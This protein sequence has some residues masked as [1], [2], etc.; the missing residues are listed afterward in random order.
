[1]VGIFS[2]FPGSP[3]PLQAT[4]VDISA[5][6]SRL[7][8]SVDS[9]PL[10]N[11]ST[12]C[13]NASFSKKYF[14][15]PSLRSLFSSVFQTQ[16]VSRAR[17]RWTCVPSWCPR[18]VIRIRPCVCPRL[19]VGLSKENPASSGIPKKSSRWWLKSVIKSGRGF[20]LSLLK[21]WGKILSQRGGKKTKRKRNEKKVSTGGRWLFLNVCLCE[22][23]EETPSKNVRAPPPSVR[24]TCGGSVCEWGEIVL[25]LLFLESLIGF[26]IDL[27]DR[28]QLEVFFLEN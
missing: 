21:S 28:A 15:L 24:F 23:C 6:A 1:M 19:R 20:A 25:L 3:I 26:G 16:S 11:P 18:R 4:L 14:A 5:N 2:P 10:Q 22:C 9:D 17:L 13:A 27:I 7:S 8:N 12:V